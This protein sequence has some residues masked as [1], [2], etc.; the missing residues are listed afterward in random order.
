MI[1]S[2]IAD[3]LTNDVRDY[4]PSVIDSSGVKELLVAILSTDD[5]ADEAIN[6]AQDNSCFDAPIYN[7]EL[8]EVFAEICGW[9]DEPGNYGFDNS[10]SILEQMRYCVYGRQCQLVWDNKNVVEE[11]V[12][13]EIKKI[14]LNSYDIDYDDDWLEVAK[15]ICS[16]LND[17]VSD[18]VDVYDADIDDD[19][20]NALFAAI[21]EA[22]ETNKYSSQ[23]VN[24]IIAG[25]SDT[26]LI[27]NL[28]RV[29]M[30]NDSKDVKFKKKK[31]FKS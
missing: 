23:Q 30:T 28:E 3:R 13:D 5:L 26:E 7:S 2:D 14:L 4:V 10:G 15:Q 6:N 8:V 19:L 22:A 1:E 31:S 24:E 20:K 21:I 16:R 11:F 25:T 18:V 12:E 27:N 29:L 9:D 17:E